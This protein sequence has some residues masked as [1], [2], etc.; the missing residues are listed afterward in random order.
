MTNIINKSFVFFILCSCLSITSAIGQTAIGK[1]MVEGSDVILDFKTNDNRGIILPWVTGAQQ[2]TTPVGGTLIFDSSDKKVKYYKGGTESTWVD[3]SIQE[4]NVD[5]GMQQPFAEDATV[6]PSVLGSR[7][8]TASGVLVLESNSKAMVLPKK[9]SPHLNIL[10]PKAGTM[11][12]D[13]VSKMLCIF[14]G[15]EWSFWKVK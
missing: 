14:N 8:S 3:L 6:T 13:T 4:G 12:F 11:A 7:T 1:K 2:V 15:K 5:L 9:E 10:S